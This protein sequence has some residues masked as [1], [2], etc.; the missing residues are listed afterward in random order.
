MKHTKLTLAL[1]VT[2]SLTACGD[3]K[4]EQG[5]SGINSLVA[6]KTLMLGNDACFFGGSKITSGLDTNAD[7]ALAD[8][9]VTNTSTNCNVNPVSVSGSPLPYSVMRSD[10]DNGALPGTLMEVRNGGFGSDMVAHPSEPTRFY[11]LTDRGPNATFT[12]DQ[13]KGKKFPTPDYTPRIG[14]FELQDNG[15]VKKIKDILLNRPDGTPITGLPNSTALGGTG[16]TP[17]DA[18]GNVIVEDMSL[19]FDETTNPIKL[20]DYGLDGEGLV[21]LADGTFWISDEYGP[22]IVHF[23]AE[24]VEIGRINAFTADTRNTFTLPA[25]FANRRANRGMEGLTVTPDETT[26]VGI[27]QSTMYNPSSAVKVNNI[28]RIVAVNLTD[29]S[30]SQYL[31]KQEKT[32]NSQSG[33]VALSNT[34]FVVIERDGSFYNEDTSAMKH[35]YKIDISNATDIETIAT[36]SNM[37]Q[38]DSLGLLINGKTLEEITLEADGWV[39]IA[40]AGIETISKTLLVDL[41]AETGYPHDKLEGLWLINDSTIGVL[42]DDDFATWASGGV[43]E[44]KYL[45]AGQTVIDGN[46]L[47]IIENLDLAH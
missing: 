35:L 27:M 37:T 22:H 28:V 8:T 34:E 30:I 9:E 4:G 12:G 40:N 14:L 39:T 45:D 31:Y 19:P 16:E 2:L 23:N 1:L 44:Q 3:D 18:D 38:D 32:Q 5:M 29:G 21:A 41:V 17:Y 11:A 20:D 36:T 13:G 26:L 24:G 10:I 46:R 47:Y 33:I 7:N 6:H 42:N 25:E 43:L 15:D